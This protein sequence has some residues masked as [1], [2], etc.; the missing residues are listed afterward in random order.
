VDALRRAARHL[1]IQAVR[2]SK[3]AG[4]FLDMI[5]ADREADETKAAEIIEATAALC[6]QYAGATETD[7]EIAAQVVA[8]VK[9]ALLAAADEAH[10]R[11]ELTEAV[12]RRLTELE[13]TLPESVAASLTKGTTNGTPVSA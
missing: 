9:D 5:D 7:A 3:L 10:T 8:S 4:N 6:R 13:T 12:E 2:R 1:R 11:E